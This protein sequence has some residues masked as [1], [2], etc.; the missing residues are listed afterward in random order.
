M[1]K[2]LLRSSCRQILVAL[3]AL[4]SMFGGCTE[5]VAQTTQSSTGSTTITVHGVAPST[6]PADAVTEK[7]KPPLSTAPSATTSFQRA[8][9][10]SPDVASFNGAGV[11]SITSRQLFQ[12]P[13]ENPGYLFNLATYGAGLGRW[14]LNRGI[15]LHGAALDGLNTDPSGGNK[16]GTVNVGFFNYGFDIDTKKAFGI[17]GGLID[18]T[19]TSQ[20]G[21]AHDGYNSLGSVT[22]DPAAFGPLVGLQSLYY[23]Q[24]LLNG[25]ADVMVG[26]ISTQV[27]LPYSTSTTLSP[28]F[29]SASWYCSFFTTGCSVP[30]AYAYDPT[31]NSIYFGSWGGVVTY[32]PAKY[33]YI[34]SG[35]FE[36]EPGQGR[37]AGLN[38]WPG[39]SWRLDYA[40]G[41]YLPV[42]L[43]YV[44]SPVSSP[45]PSDFQLGGYFDTATYNDHYYHKIDNRAS[46]LYGNLQQTVFRFSGNRK[47]VRGV[48]VFVS[49]NWDLTTLNYVHQEISAGLVI[50]GPFAKRSAD[51]LNFLSYTETFD[52]RYKESREATAAAH[53]IHYVLRDETGFEINYAVA[54]APGLSVTPYAQ[55]IINPDEI[56]LPVPNPRD[57]FALAGGIKTL[58]RFYG[59][60]GLP[61]PGQ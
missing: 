17:P 14:L 42:Q 12:I 8:E 60:F 48:A 35:A 28:G 6:T 47:S 24:R 10:G 41:T 26:R 37:V 31:K 44:T 15:Y 25:A 39:P 9:P 58:I 3:G 50:T 5:T 4:S 36:G 34:K 61:Q 59:L 20:W 51:A 7:K 16:R 13:G 49:G 43:G 2:P 23:D 40:D 54:L 21:D 1:R 30:T 11:Q 18:F 57:T 56:G 27:G 46:G 22:G 32:R 29:D 19:M 45:Y 53:H 55:Y 38:G 52:P 33:W